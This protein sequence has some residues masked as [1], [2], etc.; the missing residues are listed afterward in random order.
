[1]TLILN[2]DYTDNNDTTIDAL[3]AAHT[4][5][6]ADVETLNVN[7]T[8]KMAAI[9]TKVEGYK[10]DLVTNTLTLAGS[11]KLA[12]VV[13]TGDQAFSLAS[14]AAMTKLASVDG[15]AN[16]GGVT[17]ATKRTPTLIA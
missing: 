15:S 6:A 11:N 10:A 4:V 1:M 16:T 12:S 17:F 9:V 5:V 7:S 13:V 2:K 8:G 3:A 14:T